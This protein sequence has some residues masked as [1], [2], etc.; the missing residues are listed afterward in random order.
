[1]MRHVRSQALVWCAIVSL[2]SG[3]SSLPEQKGSVLEGFKYNWD[4][5]NHR[6]STLHV[7]SGDS[8]TEVAVVG[9]TSTTSEV[10]DLADTCDPDICDEFSFADN[11]IVDVWWSTV[12]TTDAALLPMTVSLEVGRDGASAVAVGTLPKGARGEQEDSVALLSGLSLRTDHPLAEDTEACYR[13]RYG[14]HPRQISIAAGD[15]SIN[16]DQVT[17]PVDAIFSAGKNFEE[18]RTC[19]D[20]VNTLAV[21]SLDVHL[22]VVVGADAIETIPLS[23]EASYPFVFG[24]TPEVQLEPEPTD[25]ATGIEAPLL[26]FGSMN[27]E[28]DPDRTDDRGAYLRSVGLWATPE[29]A[30]AIATNYSPGTQIFDFAYRFE[31]EIHAVEIDAEI[32]RGKSSDTFPAA[33][34]E[35]G[36]PVLNSLAH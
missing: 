21:V 32:T 31:G 33:L 24:E 18:A 23:R 19:I 4:L 8:A 30:N 34:D 2:G 26:G 29:G 3:C 17:V 20:E 7:I 15:V 27:F 5:F 35:A 28:F 9:G 12:A 22:L 16:G 1:M 36:D 25:I 6:L 14:W 13:P 10:L 11:A